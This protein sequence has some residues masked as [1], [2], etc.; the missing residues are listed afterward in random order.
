VT[1][2]ERATEICL[3]RGQDHTGEPRFKHISL[4]VEIEKA[5]IAAIEEDRKLARARFHANAALPTTWE[6]EAIMDAREEGRL[7]GA[8]ADYHQAD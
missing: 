6:W 1:P 8:A 2:K 5:I 3:R 7:E 4:V